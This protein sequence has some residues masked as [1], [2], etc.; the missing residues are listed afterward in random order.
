M[1]FALFVCFSERL[2]GVLNFE[3]CFFSITRTNEITN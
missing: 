1:S 3:D 2:S